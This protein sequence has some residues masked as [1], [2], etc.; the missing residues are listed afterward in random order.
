[1]AKNSPS[2]SSTRFSCA[3][4]STPER[5]RPLHLGGRVL[6]RPLLPP[7][8]GREG[9]PLG[10]HRLDGGQEAAALGV[11]VSP[12]REGPGVVGP[13]PEEVRASR[14]SAC[15]GSLGPAWD[16]NSTAAAIIRRMER[17]PVG[18]VVVNWNGGTLLD[19]CLD[20][21]DGQGAAR[22]LVVDNGSAPDEVRTDRGARRGLRPPARREPRLRPRFERGRRRREA[23]GAPLPRLRQQRRGPSAGLPRRLRRRARSRPVSRGRPG[24]RPRRRGAS[25]RRPGRRLER[26]GRGGPA[27]TRRGA[28]SRRRAAVPGR[29]R[30]RHR[31]G[32]P[33]RG[34]REGLGLRRV[35]LRLVRGRRPLPPPPPRRR[36]L[37]LRPGG[38]GAARGVGHRTAHSGGEVAPPL[39]EPRSG[40]C[41]GT[42][43]RRRAAPGAPPPS[44]AAPGPQGRRPRPRLPPARLTA[45]RRAVAPA[46]SPPCRRTG[47]PAGAPPLLPRLPG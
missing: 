46:S 30:L 25:R 21:L 39:R 10:L 36:A 28:A 3:A 5:L 45:R 11:E 42:S 16:A 9:V 6:L 1:M 17:L 22:V 7:H 38:A 19:S 34:L 43:S 15:G 12:S 47:P 31:A 41:G 40:R 44:R 32:L 4:T 29:R 24:G 20:A 33:A 37:R 8:L 35:V 2:I 27:R 14:R 23:Q 13:V 18:V 26:A